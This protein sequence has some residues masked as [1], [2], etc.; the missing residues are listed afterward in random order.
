MIVGIIP[1]WGRTSRYTLNRLGE[2][3]GQNLHGVVDIL[4]KSK[5]HISG[6]SDV[7][8]AYLQSL[9]EQGYN[10]FSLSPDRKREGHPDRVGLR[11][12]EL[13]I[14]DVPVKI[15]GDEIHN[16]SSL[17]RLDE[18]D[19]AFAGLDELLIHNQQWMRNKGKSVRTWGN[20]NYQLEAATDVKV[21]GSAGIVTSDGLQDFISMFLIG[22]PKKRPVKNVDP[23]VFHGTVPL[24]VKGRYE[25]I[26][27]SAYPNAKTVAVKNVEDAVASTPN[28]YGVELV[29]TGN[30]VRE[31]DLIVYGA[32]LSLSETLLVVNYGHFQKN[33]DLRRLVKKLQP[34]GF[35]DGTRVGNFVKWY[36]VLE[37]NLGDSWVNK[38]LISDVF[39]TDEEI[40]AGVR[41]YTTN[42][43]LWKASDN[44]PQ[45][46]KLE[47][48][49]YIQKRR[50]QLIL[51]YLGHCYERDAL[52]QSSGIV[53]RD[54]APVFLA[55]VNEV[56]RDPSIL[57]AR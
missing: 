23:R 37:Q 20:H 56:K 29:Q 53:F 26:V 35:Y 2:V 10:Y 39:V 3:S 48:R 36:V 22:K 17:I 42:S 52:Q 11:S 31:K 50:N 18:A 30:T 33:G 15:E 5:E 55:V 16:G 13:V 54:I 38:P 14:D 28:S 12:I 40:K 46:K 51:N 7:A 9:R 1:R 32:P 4:K 19:F 25:G 27:L 43:R 47:E 8:E 45:Q 41:P 6:S 44:L 21:V 49:M 24:F 34:Q 57:Q